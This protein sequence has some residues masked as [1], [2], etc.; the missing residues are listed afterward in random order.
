MP[1]S[2]V[3]DFG[4]YQTI[5][6]KNNTIILVQWTMAWYLKSKYTIKDTPIFHLGVS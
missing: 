4:S 2:P 3:T 1:E 5:P 6:Q